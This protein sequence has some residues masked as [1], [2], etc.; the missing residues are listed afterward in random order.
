M[1]RSATR[2]VMTVAL[3]LLFAAGAAVAQSPDSALTEEQKAQLQAMH[4][5]RNQIMELEQRLREIQEATVEASPELRAQREAFVAKLQAAMK[6]NGYDAEQELA[7]LKDLEARLRDESGSD[8]ERRALFV[9][10]Q[11]KVVGYQRAQN[12]ALEREDL[13]QAREA[14]AEAVLAAMKRRDP[15]TE[16][17]IGRLQEARERLMSLRRE[18]MQGR[19]P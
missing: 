1:Y 5:A 16:V 8:E 14:V 7:E 3:S 15:Q 19:Q 17:L 9:Q 4:A 18:V 10:F 12:Q 6:E 13:K 2:R 11:Q